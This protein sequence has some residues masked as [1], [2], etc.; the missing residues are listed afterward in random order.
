MSRILSCHKLYSSSFLCRPRYPIMSG[1]PGRASVHTALATK[2]HWLALGGYRRRGT[3]DAWRQATCPEFPIQYLVYLELTSTYHWITTSLY[4]T[5]YTSFKLTLR[6]RDIITIPYNI[7]A[8]FLRP[9][10][11]VTFLRVCLDA[12]TRAFKQQCAWKGGR[13]ERAKEFEPALG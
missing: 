7:K 12:V 11:R 3:T 1:D 2:T 8:Y 5:Y 13:G 4:S 10:F 9:L 6:Y